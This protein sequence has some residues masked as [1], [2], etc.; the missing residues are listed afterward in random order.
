MFKE[1]T[2]KKFVLKYLPIIVA[3]ILTVIVLIMYF[4]HQ[5]I[6]TGLLVVFIIISLG[7]DF[8]VEFLR[9]RENRK[10]NGS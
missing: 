2:L 10:N 9:K 8:A 3:T 4:T 1:I 6:S 5:N 7:T